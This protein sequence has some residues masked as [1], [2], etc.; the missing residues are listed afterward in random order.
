M[1]KNKK[2][3]IIE[4]IRELALIIWL[5]ITLGALVLLMLQVGQNK[6]LRRQLGAYRRGVLV[7]LQKQEDL[8]AGWERFLGRPINFKDKRKKSTSCI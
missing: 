2:L 5:A 6:L 3:T 1:T 7:E 4:K 8:I